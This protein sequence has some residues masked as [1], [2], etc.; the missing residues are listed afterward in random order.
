MNNIL[1]HRHGDTLENHTS[2]LMPYV[3]TS[4]PLLLHFN[5]V[6]LTNLLI[7]HPTKNV[8]TII[9]FVVNEQKE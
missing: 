8:I 6:W 7:S 5:V 9:C 4:V 2:F 3:V 1:H